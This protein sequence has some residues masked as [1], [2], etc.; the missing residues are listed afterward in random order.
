MKAALFFAAVYLL[1]LSWAL[2]A[3]ARLGIGGCCAIAYPIGLV[4]W[5][6]ASLCLLALRVPYLAG[7]VA[8]TWVIL[9]IGGGIAQR[10]ASHER[11]HLRDLAILGSAA[12]AFALALAVVVQWNL[13]I[14]TYDS[15][16]IVALGRSIAYHGAVPLDFASELASR[17]IVQVMIHAASVLLD[18]PYLYAAPPVLAVSFLGLFGYLG[19]RALDGP[20][21][22]SLPTISLVALVIAAMGTS[23]FV[24]VQY[25]YMHE[26]FAAA[27]FLFLFCGCFW[28]ADREREPAWLAFSFAFLLAFSLNRIEAPI[29]AALFAL[30]AH[31]RSRLP[32]RTLNA[33][34][35]AYV[36]AVAAWYALLLGYLGDG[37]PRLRTSPQI[38]NTN[39]MAAILGGTVACFA[40][41]CA[42]RLPRFARL[43][44]YMPAAIL[45][46]LTLGVVAC[47]M[48]RPAHMT[49]SALA[50]LAN[51]RDPAWGGTWYVFV[52]LGVLA[53]AL[54]RDPLHPLFTYGSGALIAVIY[55]LSFS[56]VPYMVKWGDSG[57]RMLLSAVPLWFFFLLISYG[58]ITLGRP[59]RDPGEKARGLPEQ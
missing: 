8:A 23:Y 33:W 31:S 32:S 16:L 15:H 2:S 5:V 40:A 43:R 29:I 49:E 10:A 51:L 3:R 17:G 14:W 26:N 36:V 44:P 22:P 42:V 46:A 25:F 34:A 11:F 59:L 50:I 30:I 18:V 20:G 56:R 53:V 13:S 12:A 1:G 4:I 21:R 55:L 39:R 7:P 48:L 47:V 35:L 37:E 27:V 19:C 57:H 41:G 24:V 9:V 45:G 54:P 28:L 38:L 58:P 6:L 52:G